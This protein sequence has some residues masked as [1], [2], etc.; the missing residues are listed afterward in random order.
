MK[1]VTAVAAGYAAAK[2]LAYYIRFFVPKEEATKLVLILVIGYI[3][4]KVME[5]MPKSEP[6]ADGRP[7]WPTW[8]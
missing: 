1:R 7:E 5:E 6:S 2:L 8:A 4:S 3:F